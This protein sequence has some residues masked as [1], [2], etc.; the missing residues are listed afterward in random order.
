MG[1]YIIFMTQRW[2][3]IPLKCN[4]SCDMIIVKHLSILVNVYQH[5]LTLIVVRVLYSVLHI[6]CYIE[7]SCATVIYKHTRYGSGKNWKQ[8]TSVFLSDSNRRHEQSSLSPNESWEAVWSFAKGYHH[9]HNK[10]ASSQ[11][12]GR[13]HLSNQPSHRDNVTHQRISISQPCY[14]DE[15][16]ECF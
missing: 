3:I 7:I 13:E 9:D 4:M 5:W 10:Q 14:E 12:K 8:K 2:F 6:V 11:R 16:I 1:L 15:W